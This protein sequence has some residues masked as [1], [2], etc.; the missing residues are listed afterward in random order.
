[1]DHLRHAN[2][3]I[4]EEQLDALHALKRRLGRERGRRLTLDI[5][6]REAVELL[7]RHHEAAGHRTTPEGSVR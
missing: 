4:P 5:I 1:M 3:T 6:V 7:L 2:L